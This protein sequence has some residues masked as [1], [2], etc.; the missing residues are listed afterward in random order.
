MKRKDIHKIAPKLS[1]IPLKKTGFEIPKNYFESV[2]DAV[3]SELKAET[4]LKKGNKEAFNTPNNYFDSI[5]EI[6][7]T[8]LKA[9]AIQN[10]NET[11][12]P[13]KL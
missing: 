3:I 5:E 1:E 8:K 11:T 6:V 2:E 10:D 7:I 12:I 4:L 13:E 9:E